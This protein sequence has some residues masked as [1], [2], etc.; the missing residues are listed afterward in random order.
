MSTSSPSISLGISEPL[1]GFQ[2]PDIPISQF[3]SPEISWVDLSAKRGFFS[4]RESYS[5]AGLSDCCQYAF[6]YNDTRISTLSLEGCWTSSGS[7]RTAKPEN[8]GS[9]FVHQDRILDV[10][11]SRR[12]LVVV[13]TSSIL[14]KNVTNGQMIDGITHGD[15]DTSGVACR[16]SGERVMIA[17]ARGRGNRSNTIGQIEIY[18]Y[19][20]GTAPRKMSYYS[21]MELPIRDRPKKICLSHDGR[22]LTCVTTIQNKLLIWHLDGNHSAMTAPFVF[23]K[24]ASTRVRRTPPISASYQI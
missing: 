5:N 15:W 21:T 14:I 20:I 6:F 9:D 8:L 3:K 24:N 7:I 2:E 13:T 19:T 18:Q 17:L 22:I 12:F 4:R 10:V 16:E 23:L 1:D 11:M